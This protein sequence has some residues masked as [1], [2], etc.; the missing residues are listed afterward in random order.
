MKLDSIKTY[1]KQEFLQ[2]PNGR[3]LFEA[4]W[5]LRYYGHTFIANEL[6]NLAIELLALDPVFKVD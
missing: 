3:S 4:S 1:D 2:N 5:L 6:E